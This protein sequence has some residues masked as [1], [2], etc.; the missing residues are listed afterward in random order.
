MTVIKEK[1]V[2]LV[3]DEDTVRNALSRML[4]REGYRVHVAENGEEGLRVLKEKPIHLVISDYSMPKMTGLEFLK[5]VRERHPD[6]VR[7]MLTANPNSEVVVRSINE[8]E[9]YR[10]IRKPWDKTALR[11]IL[12]FAFEAITRDEEN[13]RLLS[14]LRPQVDLLLDLERDFPYLS[15]LARDEGEPHKPDAQQS[16][17]AAR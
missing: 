13:R 3:E 9:V 1:H 5:L 16:A 12:H 10:F 6:V 15:A 11:V 4:V 17:A 8:G 14:V 2:L 7:V